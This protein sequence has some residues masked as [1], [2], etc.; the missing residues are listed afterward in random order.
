MGRRQ[1]SDSSV[2][3]SFY[4]HFAFGQSEK[5]KGEIKAVLHGI[6]VKNWVQTE[7]LILTEGSR[8]TRKIEDIMS[9]FDLKA[10][11]KPEPPWIFEWGCGLFVLDGHHRVMAA[12]SLGIEKIPVNISRYR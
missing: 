6:K 3:G 8:C 7:C 5:V 9:D 12:L 1:V 10:F 4:G 11:I 2:V